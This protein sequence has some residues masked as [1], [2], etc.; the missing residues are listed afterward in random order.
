MSGNETTETPKRKYLFEIAV[1]RWR[2][3]GVVAESKEEAFATVEDFA[4][5][6]YPNGNFDVRFISDDERRIE[7][8]NVGEWL[9]ASGEIGE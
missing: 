5:D 1:T 7:L 8:N 3:V 9:T 6:E 2:D 4:S